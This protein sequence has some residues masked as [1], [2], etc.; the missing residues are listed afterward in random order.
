MADLLFKDTF[1]RETATVVG[2]GTDFS[3][4]RKVLAH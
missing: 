1:S 3:I 2:T 4:G